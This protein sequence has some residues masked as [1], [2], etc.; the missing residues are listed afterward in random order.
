MA[1][2]A[3]RL[4]AWWLA[5]AAAGCH[6]PPGEPLLGRRAAKPPLIPPC[7]AVTDFENLSNF[8]GQWNLGGG[9]A[10]LLSAALLDSG[11]VT[12]L[13]RRNLGDVVGEITRQGER[14]FRGEGRVARGRL[15][16]ARYLVRGAVTDF[17][18]TRKTSGALG[19]SFFRLF[20]R[21]GKARV[22]IAVKVSDVE[23]GEIIT[24]V[25]AARSVS[26]GGVGA[27]GR[28]GD[29]AFGGDAFFRTPL[30]RATESAIAEAVRGI[31]RKL[32]REYWQ[33]RV[34]EAGQDF[35][36]LNGGANVRLREGA[37]F[38]VRG[39][40]RTIT[41]PV[42]GNIIETV[43]GKVVGRLRVTDVL[44][45]SAHAVL[46]EGEARRGDRLEPAP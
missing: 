35:V 19:T 26:S 10:D 14:L 39:E 34:A 8:S 23:T 29:L 40:G 9:M 6:T 7:L 2:T 17:T 37:L 32:P 16:N 42:T 25:R 11:Q 18:E 31:L 33:P 12:V 30:G 13:E 3:H 4:F 24:T 45:T 20:G 41:D 38:H 36:V 1:R 15:K 46:L 27:E 21:G 28:K 44:E 43:P 22:A 5:L